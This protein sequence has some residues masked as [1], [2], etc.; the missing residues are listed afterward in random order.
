MMDTVAQ[1]RSPPEGS[2]A[3]HQVAEVGGED[4]VGVALEEG[5]VQVQVGHLQHARVSAHLA[6]CPPAACTKCIM[7]LSLFTTQHNT[8]L[9]GTDSPRSVWTCRR[10]CRGPW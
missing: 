6:P 3:G 8:A 7:S 9:H 4:D 1:A 5:V 10:G 2:E